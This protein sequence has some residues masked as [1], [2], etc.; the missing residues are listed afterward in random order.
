[1]IHDITIHSAVD[2]YVLYLEPSNHLAQPRPQL[3]TDKTDRWAPESNG[4]NDTEYHTVSNEFV[5]Y[6]SYGTVV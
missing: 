6:H 5:D 2:T 3:L 4:K 1:M